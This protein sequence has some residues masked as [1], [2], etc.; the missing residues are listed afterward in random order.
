MSEAQF[1]ALANWDRRDVMYGLQL[2]VGA[3]PV[4]SLSELLRLTHYLE[5]MK[6]VHFIAA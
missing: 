2:A 3:Q 4:N 1:A 5:W 6:Q